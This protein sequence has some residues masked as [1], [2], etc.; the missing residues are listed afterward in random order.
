[1]LGYKLLYPSVGITRPC[2][3]VLQS[4]RSW[5]ARIAIATDLG[6]G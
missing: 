6:L 3:F 5:S 2:P 1:M 4:H